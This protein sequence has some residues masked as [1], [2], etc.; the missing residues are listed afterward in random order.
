MTKGPRSQLKE[1]PVLRSR[2]SE[3]EK[4]SVVLNHNTEYKINM[5]DKYKKI[6]LRNRGGSIKFST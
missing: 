2:T 6:Q 3:Q 5:Y 1:P 4:I